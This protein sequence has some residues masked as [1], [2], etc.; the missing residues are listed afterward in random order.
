MKKILHLKYKRFIVAFVS[1][2]LIFLAFIISIIASQHHEMEEEIESDAQRELELIGS[3]AQEALLMNDYAGVEQFLN[4]WSLKHEEILSLTATAPNAFILVQFKSGKEGSSILNLV[5]HVRYGGRELLLL[6]MTKD[7]SPAQK[8]MIKLSLPLIVSSVFLTVIIGILLWYAMSKL[9]LIPMEKEILIREQAERKFRLLL[10]SAP[11]ALIYADNNGKILMV[12]AQTELLFGYNRN[13]LEGKGIEILMPTRFRNNHKA[14][15]EKFISKPESRP[16]GLDM[17]LYGITKKGREFP[18]DISLSPIETE[19]GL[20]IFSAIREITERKLAEEKLKRS[21][22]FQA[23]ISSILSKSLS[24]ADLENQLQSILDTILSIPGLSIESM[25]CIYLAEDDS[26]SLTMKAQRGLPETIKSACKSIPFSHCLCGEAAE[27]RRII[28]ASCDDS[29]HM[30]HPD[31]GKDFPHGHYCVPIVSGD[32]TLGV[33]NLVVKKDHK[34]S[35]DEEELLT[36]V[37]NTLAGIIEHNR[38]DIERQ[39]LQT[40]LAQVEKLSALGRFTANVAHEIRTPLTLIGG[41]ARRLDKHIPDG[42]KDKEYSD[43][44]INEVSRLENILKNVLTYSRESSLN[45]EEHNLSEIITSSLKPYQEKYRAQSIRIDLKFTEIPDLILDRDQVIEV[46]NNI[47]SNA[48]D[49]MPDG[50]SFTVTN[51]SSTVHGNDYVIVHF[52]D[53]GEGMTEEQ[54]QMIFEPFYSTKIIG[55]GTGLGLPISKKIMEDHDGFITVDT[56]LK[57][58]STFSL[59]FPLKKDLNPSKQKT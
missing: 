8:S 7:L 38:T 52:T 2:L 50:G 11:D 16:M 9:A 5:H 17:E 28:F 35:R 3:F 15:R 6:E 19:E 54:I 59:Y 58:G 27:S 42:I 21:Y 57:K 33:I 47:L 4:Q 13:E 45:M 10:E 20:F 53:T 31:Y 1:I 25:G 46:L 56:E 43:I 30:D 51:E 49:A 41:F 36:S 55:H 32:K 29:R 23:A 26:G 12:N 22:N 40:Q 44:I 39:H 24:L 18:A 37:A 14:F 34:K 48:F